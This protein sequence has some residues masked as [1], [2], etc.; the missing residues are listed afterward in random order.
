MNIF[1]KINAVQK[2]QDFIQKHLNEPITLHMIAAEANYSPWHSV[3]VF[4]ELTGKTPFDY[5]RR[6]RLSKAAIKLRDERIKVVD[7]ALDFVFDSHEGFTRAFSK[8]FGITPVKYS[9][10]YP[11]IKLFIPYSIRDH[12][13]IKNN[14]ESKKDQ[15][16]KKDSFMTVF[17]QVIERPA[18]KLILKRG[19]KAVDYYG[20]C[21]EVGCDVWGVLTSI[22]EAL[23]EP[24][25][26]W[27][28]EQF[29]K[30]GSS[31]FVQGVE[32]PFVYDGLVPEGFD[33]I[34]LKP[35]KMMI[36]QG[37]PYEDEKFQE[38]IGRT[39]ETIENYQPEIYGFE[40]ALEDG[41]RF[42]LAPMGNRGYIEG[43]P[44]RQINVS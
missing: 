33:I 4:K 40:W 7:V 22:K 2:M 25:G 6:L 21:Q 3:R 32:V 34:D 24:V 42:Q 16:I 12:H 43:R 27:L 1:E 38:A 5:I 26:L 10:S 39:I 30:P 29:R 17:V 11:P 15:N 28:P 18:R 13:I 37:P 14:G 8:E 41:P 35:C 31:I 20:Y 23:C 36:F 9:K 44:V 19:I